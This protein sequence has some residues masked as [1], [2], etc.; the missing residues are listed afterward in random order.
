MS[1]TLR[2]RPERPIVGM[3]MGV[4]V[5]V[6]FAEGFALKVA[7]LLALCLVVYLYWTGLREKRE[8]RRH[9]RWQESKRREYDEKI[10]QQKQSPPST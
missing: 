10:A 4:I 7:A 3:G 8:V 9:R 2:L 1:K 6:F 5:P